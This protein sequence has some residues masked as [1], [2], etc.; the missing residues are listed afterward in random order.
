MTVDILSVTFAVAILCAALMG[1]AIQRGATC[2][3]AA[4]GEIVQTGKA[5][6]LIALVEAALWV[7]SGVILAQGLGRVTHLPLGYD[8]TI[9]TLVG[10]AI[11]GVGAFVNRACV[12]G[13][14]AKLGSGNW[15]Y[16]LTPVGYFLGAASF[17]QD[18][19][20]GP[21]TRG[22]ILDHHPQLARWIMLVAGLYLAGRLVTH[23]I[24]SVRFRR[25]AEAI[26][27]PHQATLVIGMTFT[28]L[29][30]LVGSWSYTEF[31]EQA[32]VAM[33]KGFGWK[34]LLFGALLVGAIIGGARSGRLSL[35]MPA[36]IWLVRCF[37]GGVMM[38]WGSLLIPGS[39]DGLILVGMPFLLPHAW[40]A[41]AA[42]CATI[43]L[44]FTVTRR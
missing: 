21:P 37:L 32:S 27:S 3:V 25:P 26:W 31:L 33:A 23:V 14:I 4:V 15:A 41:M 24:K 16:V 18:L 9:H 10:G 38:G 36:P 29:F 44:C 22:A 12:F 40:V 19:R 13:A 17:P 43:W 20:M 42:M 35:Q 6:K 30:V 8:V 5:S 7:S 11:L 34:G 39:N 2:A 28:I 1:F